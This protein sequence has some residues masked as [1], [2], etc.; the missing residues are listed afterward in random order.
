M[1]ANP[2]IVNC[3]KEIWTIVAAGVTSA[4]IYK[5]NVNPSLYLQTYRIEGDTPPSDNSDAA[6]LFPGGVL[7]ATISNDVKIDVYIKPLGRDGQV[8][9]DV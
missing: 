2:E 7:Y 1:H 6:A 5:I 4:T 8:R 3:P 9:L